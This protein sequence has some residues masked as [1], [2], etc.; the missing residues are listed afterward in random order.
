[1]SPKINIINAT[2]AGDSFIAALIHGHLNDFPIE[3]SVVFSIATSIITMRS[4][5][6][7]SKNISKD[8][9]NKIIKEMNIC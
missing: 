2:G 3:K 4:H 6:T 9:I 7:V 1:K 5:D 8:N